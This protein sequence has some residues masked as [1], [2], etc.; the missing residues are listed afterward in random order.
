MGTLRIVEIKARPLLAGRHATG[1][2][3]LGEKML[4]AAHQS[5]ET[6]IAYG[7]KVKMLNPRD[8]DL[9]L[10]HCILATR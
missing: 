8:R 1:S 4:R 5:S 9:H 10:L 2:Q 6:T 3:H 7:F